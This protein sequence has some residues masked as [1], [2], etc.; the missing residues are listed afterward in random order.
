MRRETEKGLRVDFKSRMKSK[1]NERQIIADLFKSQK[2]CEQLDSNKVSLLV[3]VSTRVVYK[4]LFDICLHI[5]LSF[6]F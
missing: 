5:Y 6:F 2:A 4:K 1:L 3:E